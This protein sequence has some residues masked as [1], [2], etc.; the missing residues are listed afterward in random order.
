MDPELQKTGIERHQKNYKFPDNKV[1]FVNVKVSANEEKFQNLLT[2][3]SMTLGLHTCGPLANYQ[4]KA[5]AKNKIKGIISLGCCFDKLTRDEGTQNISHFA[6]QMSDQLEFNQYALTLATRAHRKM[7][8]KDYAFKLKVKFYRY[9]IHFLL[10]DIYGIKEI[11]TLGNTHH[12]IYDGPFA[13]Y[14]LEQ[15]KR[16][17][18]EAHHTKDELNQYFARNDVQELIWKMLAAG[19]IR[20]ALGRPMELYILLDRAIYLSEQGYEVS[21]LEFFEESLSPRNIGI[22]A[23]LS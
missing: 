4:I 21:V 9:A 3:N 8:E 10:H 6:Q 15:L 22:V 2:R 16:I 11:V 1:E 19:L 20:N 14:A 17:N 18:L 13:D 7:D 5:S 23:S 12:K